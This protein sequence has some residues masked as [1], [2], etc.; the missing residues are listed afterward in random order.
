MG[1]CCQSDSYWIKA[2][3]QLLPPA[4]P[5][6]SRV[7]PAG[8]VFSGVCTQGC[9]VGKNGGVPG[10]LLWFR[11]QFWAPLCS[12]GLEPGRPDLQFFL[13]PQLAESLWTSPLVSG[14]VS[15]WVGSSASQETV[16]A[17]GTEWERGA[18]EAE[19]REGP[20]SPG[21]AASPSET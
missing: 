1:R 16:E 11:L 4:R 9:T 6:P 3:I 13:C 8:A 14:P 20:R 15:C 21:G 17:E 10:A 19:V 18:S 2:P 12:V 7:P 5:L